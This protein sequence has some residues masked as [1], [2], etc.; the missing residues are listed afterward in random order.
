M[1]FVLLVVFIG[2]WTLVVNAYSKRGI[3]GFRPQILGFCAGLAAFIVASAVGTSIEKGSTTSASPGTAA[4]TP[5]ASATPAQPQQ[6]LLSATAENLFAEYDANEVSADQM[7]KG[8]P[9]VVVGAVQSIDKDAFNNIVVH[10]ETP[11]QF[12]SVSATLQDKYESAAAQMRKRDVVALSCVGAGRLIGSP[13][14][15]DCSPVA[16]DKPAKKKHG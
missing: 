3:K 10:L 6:P 5:P 8:K 4:A 9:L 15:K 1:G 7:Y 14:L 2:A 16:L 11:N 12:M 13:I